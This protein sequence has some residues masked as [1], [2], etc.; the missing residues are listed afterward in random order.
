MK[1]WLGIDIGTSSAKAVLIDGRGR[2]LRRGM[3]PYPIR[4]ASDGTAEQ[5]PNLY[6][7]AVRA[8]AARV[9]DGNVAGIGIVGQ[10]PTLV[11]VDAA[12][13]SIGP[14]LTWQDT[15]PF[16]EAAEMA[17]RFGDSEPLI[18]TSLA[19]A[20][21]N[22]PAKSLW[23]ARNRPSIVPRTRWLMQPKDFITLRLTGV[24]ASDAWSSKGFC[25]VRTGDPVEPILEIGGWRVDQV[26][27]IYSAW[28]AVGAVNAGGVWSG[29]PVGTPVAVGWS[30]ALAG[31]LALGVFR[32]PTGFVLTGSS[33][34]V[35]AS[36]SSVATKTAPLFEVPISCA[37]MPV[38]Y[39]PTQ[40]SGASIDW[41]AGILGTS[42]RQ[43]LALAARSSPDRPTF[44]PYI[45]GERA[46]VWRTD[47]A[48]AFL[49][50]RLGHGPAELAAAVLDGITGSNRHVLDTVV[51]VTGTPVKDVVM[52]QA[53]LG[54]G[55]AAA[56]AAGLG[57]RVA[58]APEPQLSAFGGAILAAA[59]SD[60]PD[61]AARR[62][63]PKPAPIVPSPDAVR[64]AEARS[65]RYLRAVE[66]SL[67]WGN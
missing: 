19:W 56:R 29:L 47:V 25:N 44:V 15:R 9:A 59:M 21:A 14:A 2:V 20:P 45:A 36:V 26:P 55:G 34:I 28:A 61:E 53:N 52:G 67:Q 48:G 11:C 1:T 60:G 24:A 62:L 4:R 33:D 65:D 18:G 51:E 50:L 42:A 64:A 3:H 10:T 32:R 38:V 22:L 5:Q 49:G 7:V 58:I 39:G 63:G 6:L 30:D 43:T 13:C 17:E 16:A 46:P 54:P 31:M 27:P 12:G 40:A 23:L 35:G 66:V 37:P 41:L 8:L 57:R